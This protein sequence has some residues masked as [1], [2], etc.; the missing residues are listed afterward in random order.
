MGLN[1]INGT[2]EWDEKIIRPWA[3]HPNLLGIIRESVSHK[4]TLE[5]YERGR[6]SI[7]PEAKGA[8][9]TMEILINVIRNSGKR[10]IENQIR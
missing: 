9:N 5:Q 6:S 3:V 4:G 10:M 1:D 8:G 7:V 2:A